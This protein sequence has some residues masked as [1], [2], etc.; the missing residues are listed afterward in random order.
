MR[1]A[2][3]E[4]NGRT[5]TLETKMNEAVEVRTVRRK[6]V[7]LEKQSFECEEWDGDENGVSTG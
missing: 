4:L 1:S 3:C 7:R 2:R 5:D 6:W